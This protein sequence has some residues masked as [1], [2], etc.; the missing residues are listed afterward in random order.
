M[1]PEREM[2]V[3]ALLREPLHHR[4][5][6]LA[7]ECFDAMID[8]RV[9]AE[10]A[11]AQA[12]ADREA[13]ADVVDGLARDIDTAET[14]EG[15]A[16]ATAT[17]V[18]ASAVRDHDTAIRERD[19]ARAERD[20]AILHVERLKHSGSTEYEHHGRTQQE[21]DSALTALA[22]ERTA[23][24]AAE[25]L[26]EQNYAL[27]Q[28]EKDLRCRHN[29]HEDAA[30]RRADAAE[31]ALVA[32]R[33]AVEVMPRTLVAVWGIEENPHAHAWGYAKGDIERA[34]AATPATLAGQVR[35]RVLREAAERWV[36]YAGTEGVV[37]WLRSLADE[38]EK[39]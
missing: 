16:L 23:R 28:H 11:E 34:L 9:R 27:A 38:A 12:L 17:R 29:A 22:T 8:A 30:K 24:E 2:K 19:E 36:L 6:S 26:A 15:E 37:V 7:E 18:A 5:I 3:R 35:A 1:T 13:Q 25:R 31:S 33:E 21:R 14:R 39:P 32:L 4:P 10:R 20:A